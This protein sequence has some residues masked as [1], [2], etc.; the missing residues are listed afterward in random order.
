MEF[1]IGAGEFVG[2]AGRHAVVS[3][4]QQFTQDGE[5]VVGAVRRSQPR[6]LDFQAAPYLQDVAQFGAAEPAQRTRHLTRGADVGAVPL[7]HLQQPGVRQRT[8]SFAHGVAAH[9]QCFDQ[10]GL[11]GDALPDGPLPDGDCMAQLVD[12]LVD[13]PGAARSAQRHNIPF[14][15]I[16]GCMAL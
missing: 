6:G 3:A 12:D 5:V 13:Q 10:H 1:G 16:M 11:V 15:P 9:P 14:R 2:V 8:D 7:A 4:E